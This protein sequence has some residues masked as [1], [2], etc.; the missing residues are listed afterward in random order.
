MKRSSQNVFKMA[1]I[2]RKQWLYKCIKGGCGLKNTFSKNP[3]NS[4]EKAAGHM[5]PKRREV[6]DPLYDAHVCTFNLK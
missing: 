1:L 6:N 2:E 3:K 4:H 5:L